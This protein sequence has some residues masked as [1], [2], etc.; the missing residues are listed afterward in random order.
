MVGDSPADFRKV[1]CRRS[2]D[3]AEVGQVLSRQS[4][5]AC[6]RDVSF[7]PILLKKSV[8]AVIPIFPA[9]LMRFLGKD[10]GDLIA[11]RRSDVDRYKSNCEA[12]DGRF[13]ISTRFELICA[14]FRLRTFSTK[15]AQR[16]SQRMSAC[17][18]SG[19]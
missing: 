19:V 5:L 7:W 14:L 18:L 4:A 13:Q 15:S 2:G 8:D 6:W 17:Q 3:C 10:A 11:Q 12:I 16:R 1:R 9:S